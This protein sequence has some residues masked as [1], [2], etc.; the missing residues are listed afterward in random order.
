MNIVGAIGV[1]LTILNLM[2]L[3][4]MVMLHNQKQDELIADACT[5]LTR[6]SGGR[7]TAQYNT[8]STGLSNLSGNPPRR[9]VVIA[10]VQQ[11]PSAVSFMPVASATVVAPGTEDATSAQPASNVQPLAFGFAQEP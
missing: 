4:K 2:V 3:Y 5:E 9:V 1:F 8:H 10:P 6:S 11:G 7:L